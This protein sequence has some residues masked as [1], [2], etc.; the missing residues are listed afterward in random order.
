MDAQFQVNQAARRIAPLLAAG[1][2][3]SA[4][5][6][7]CGSWGS[8]YE[9]TTAD[10]ETLKCGTDYGAGRHH[11]CGGNRPPPIAGGGV[12]YLIRLPLPSGDA[13]RFRRAGSLIEAKR[14]VWEISS[15]WFIASGAM[16]INCRLRCD[17]RLSDETR[18]RR[19]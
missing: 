5:R 19:R 12:V 6:P 16:D 15:E 4:S 10:S 17:E 18:R 8:R 7:S 1:W 14:S 13:N 2:S 11:R 9:A 3:L